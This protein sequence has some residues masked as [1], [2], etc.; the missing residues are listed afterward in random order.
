MVKESREILEDEVLLWVPLSDFLQLVNNFV[1]VNWKTVILQ[2]T[3]DGPPAFTVSVTLNW[4]HPGAVGHCAQARR[5][6]LTGFSP[7]RS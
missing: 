1:K 5:K 6:D 4:F 2:D 7:R 3:V